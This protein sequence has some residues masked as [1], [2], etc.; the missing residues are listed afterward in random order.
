[1]AYETGTASDC[2]DL[3][4]KL[5]NFLTTDSELVAESQNWVQVWQPGSNSA[6]DGNEEYDVVLR[7]PGLTASDQVYVGMRLVPD[8]LNDSAAICMVGMTG[9]ISTAE[10][11]YD[12]INVTPNHGV[13]CFL[14]GNN[15][16]DYWFV[17]NGRRFIAIV[18]V[19]T[20][21]EGLYGGLFL[22]YG[23]PTQYSYPLFIGGTAGNTNGTG[24]PDDWRDTGT[25]HT[26]FH[27]SQYE[28]SGSNNANASAHMLDPS[29][30][31]LRIAITEGEDQNV[32]M[33][34]WE[35]FDSSSWHIDKSN[36]SQQISYTDTHA[37]IIQC[38]G[39]DF[40]L[41]PIGPVTNTPSVCF[42]GV[43]E[44]VYHV[45]GRG[46]SAENIV[47]AEGV[48]HICFPNVFRTG[49]DQFFAVALGHPEDSN[50]LS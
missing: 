16:M 18:Q 47:T 15:P 31:W 21:Y 4:S 22:P 7:G 24:E 3:Y 27:R 49:I 29:G 46:N 11:Y 37:R 34:P 20:V 28:S 40:P 35:F 19:S 5:I 23:D 38:F 12:H 48:D 42:Y 50:S 44:G 10:N 2:F 33:T 13:R 1:M 45:P 14:R 26:F 6:G 39:D 41:V 25:Y 36:S 17:A 30:N 8:L 9:I 32:G 43:L